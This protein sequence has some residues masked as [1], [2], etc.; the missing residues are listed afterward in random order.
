MP[1]C[2]DRWLRRGDVRVDLQAVG[3]DEDQTY[4]LIFM[5]FVTPNSGKTKLP[6]GAFDSAQLRQGVRWIVPEGYSCEAQLVTTGSGAIR[7]R[8]ALNGTL[9]RCHA[10][11]YCQGTCVAAGAGL[12]GLWQITGMRRPS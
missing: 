2:R 4:S 9:A 7:T 3:A 6:G 8:I 5:L 10:G 1:M 11:Q 12:A